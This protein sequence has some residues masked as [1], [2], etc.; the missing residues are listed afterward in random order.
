MQAASFCPGSRPGSFSM[1]PQT[2]LCPNCGNEWNI[3]LLSLVRRRWPLW[4]PACVQTADA[5]LIEAMQRHPEKDAAK[6]PSGIEKPAE[7]GPLAQP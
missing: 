2:V 4:C 5:R 3:P 7:R 6:K 1:K